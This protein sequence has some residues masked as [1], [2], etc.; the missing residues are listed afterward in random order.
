MNNPYIDKSKINENTLALHERILRLF[1]PSKDVADDLHKIYLGCTNIDALKDI[2]DKIVVD[3]DS[4]K[5][6]AEKY[7][8]KTYP[9]AI[10]EVEN[11]NEK[12]E[13]YKFNG[14]KVTVNSKQLKKPLVLNIGTKEMSGTQKTDLSNIPVDGE[15]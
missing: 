2:S 15:T 4:F 11:V 14:T 3:E 10:I 1:Q 12:T 6:K 7:F 9:D 5:S 13:A 8:R